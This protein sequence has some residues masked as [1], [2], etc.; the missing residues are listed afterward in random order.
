MPVADPR[1]PGTLRGRAQIPLRRLRPA[2]QAFW[3]AYAAYRPASPEASGEMLRR[4][5]RFAGVRLLVTAFEGAQA[6]S[7]LRPGVSRCC[8]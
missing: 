6:V 5:L 8:R 1:D 3:T 4:S 2:V 7:E